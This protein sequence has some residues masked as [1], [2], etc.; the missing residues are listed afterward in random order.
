MSEQAA[1]LAALTEMGG[2]GVDVDGLVEVEG[3]GVPKA[4]P[5]PGEGKPARVWVVREGCY[6]RRAMAC[7]TKSGGKARGLALS[8][9]VWDTGRRSRLRGRA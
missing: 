6:W 5:E 3:W 8:P 2:Q 1:G 9:R 4:C 7:S